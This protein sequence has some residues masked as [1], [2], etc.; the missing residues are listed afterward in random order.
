MRPQPFSWLKRKLNIEPEW[1]SLKN[2]IRPHRGKIVVAVVVGCY[3]F[4][5]QYLSKK[6]DEGKKV[7]SRW[8]DPQL[9]R[10][11]PTADIL[12]NL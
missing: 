11:Q 6:V 5:R 8:L 10:G 9:T 12:E 3:P 1:E 7:F 4:Y 2:H